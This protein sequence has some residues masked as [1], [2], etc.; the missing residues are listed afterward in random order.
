[1]KKDIVKK[2]RILFI[3]NCSESTI[4]AQDRDAKNWAL[5][6]NLS[7]YEISIFC[8]GDADKRIKQKENIRIIY[9]NNKLKVAR[10]LKFLGG[11][12]FNKYDVV[13][14]NRFW[15]RAH[16]LAKINRFLRNGRKVIVPIVN[17][18]PYEEPAF[19][20]FK[21][22]NVNFFAISDKIKQGIRNYLNVDV[23]VVHLCYDLCMFNY[24]PHYNKRKKIIC[25]SS[26]Q[27]RKQPFLFANLAKETPEADFMWVGDGYYISMLKEKI[28]NENISNLKMTGIMTQSELANLLPNCDI[29]IL[30]SI[31]EGFPNVI[32]EAMAS[33]LPVIAFNTYGP[34]AV[35]NDKT[36][37]VVK[38]EFEMLER[39]KYLIS[40][41]AV[42][43]DFSENARKRAMDFEGSNIIHELE[44]YIENIMFNCI[45][46]TKK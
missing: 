41:E 3:A 24:E 11:Y 9:L 46:A 20:H 4:Q 23:P 29:F 15:S 1:M 7:K 36:G 12:I 28:K 31:H 32:A 40:N 27:A 5:F 34:E 2:I 17:Q 18:V 42:L 21:S 19:S 14:V 26:L 44:D 33:G 38:S 8:I 10:Y 6:L 45:Y 35:I 39:L 22:G 13:I 43:K 16:G 25:V 37:Y 30:P